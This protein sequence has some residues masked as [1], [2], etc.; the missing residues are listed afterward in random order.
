MLY[1]ALTFW[2]LVIVLTAW[3]VERLWSGMVRPKILNTVLLPGTLVAQIGLVLGLRWVDPGF[4]H[5]RRVSPDSRVPSN[6]GA[7]NRL[8]AIQPPYSPPNTL[9]L[10]AAPP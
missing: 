10:T 3:G 9:A 4:R 1:L 8:L 6:A 2:L 5:Q 7:L